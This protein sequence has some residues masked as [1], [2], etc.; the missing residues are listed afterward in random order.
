MTSDVSVTN[1]KMRTVISIAITKLLPKITLSNDVNKMRNEILLMPL[2]NN[3]A[4]TLESL[5][6]EKIKRIIRR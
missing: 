3:I 1:N 6:H 4:G 5:I 2:K